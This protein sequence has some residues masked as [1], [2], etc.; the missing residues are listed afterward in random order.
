MVK[1]FRFLKPYWAQ[2]LVLVATIGLQAWATLMLPAL[3]AKIVNEGI[4]PKDSGIIWSIGFQMLGFLIL[5]VVTNLIANF[6]SAKVSLK[7]SRDLRSAIYAKIL[8]FSITEINNFS[9]ASLINRTTKDITQVQQTITMLLSMAIRVPLMAI[10]AIIQAFATAPSMT[11]IIALVVGIMFITVIIIIA[12]VMP[13]LNLWQKLSDKITLLTRENLTGL[14]V[15][16]AFNNESLEHGKFSQTNT[17]L[18]KTAM[19]IDTVM[20]LTNPLLTLIFNG[21][22]LLCIWIGVSLMEADASYLGN[23]MAFMQYA[24]Q[25]VMS[26]LLLTMLFI[27][28]PRTNIAA[29]RINAVLDTKNK[30]K[31]PEKTKGTPESATSIEFENV[32]FRYPDAEEYVLEDINFK[33]QAGETIAF[34]GSTGSGKSTLVNLIPRFYDP[35]EGKILL[36]SL[37]IKHYSAKDL[38]S[39]LGLVPQKGVLFSGT[40]K[41]NI[42]FGNPNLSDED[43]K[44]AAKTAQAADFIEKMPK[45][46]ASHVARGGANLSGGQKQR[47]SIARAIAK[48]PDFYLFDDAFS[49]LDLKTDAKLRKAL[50]PV[51]KDAITLIIAQR[52]STIKSADQIIVLDRGNIV[53]RGT[54]SSLLKSCKIYREIAESQMSDQEFQKELKHA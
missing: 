53:G 20:A 23:M 49:A 54:H 3:M 5:A 18:T 44:T 1:L 47:L 28:V 45:K 9:T 15:I 29:K 4:V 34:I 21:T 48:H 17:N 10:G 46:Y 27:M 36:N 32:C 2:V 25:V 38:M 7:L 42:S 16:R 43:M 30:I 33:V 14:R 11:W 13:K 39:R 52:I 19:F 41:S 24:I 26:F 51:T 35:T 50:A 37:D 40:I 6:F 8:T 22:S 12:I 31:W